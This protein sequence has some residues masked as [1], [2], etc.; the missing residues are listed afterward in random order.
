MTNQADHADELRILGCGDAAFLAEFPNLDSVL[1]H[2][3]GLTKGGPAAGSLPAGVIDVVPAARTILVTF[4]PSVIEGAAVHHWIR[5]TPPERSGAPVGSEV[6]IE[7]RY[8]GPDLSDVAH[9][10]GVSEAQVVNL[11]TGSAWTA[12][13][14][15][16]APGFVYL[17]TD[18]ARLHV[19]RRSNP[20]TTV[21]AGAVGL[22]GE[23]S[24]VYPRQS[25]GGWQLIGTTT[26]V[27]WD[28]SRREPALIQPGD[29][30][31]FVEA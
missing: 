17:V 25:P 12:A 22:A 7:V 2:Y 3:R 21:P 20:R 18:H 31:R 4:N 24:G 11:H 13:F 27:L 19:P 30:V 9:H 29:T 6:Q 1:A 10:L 5:S 14:S 15:G 8:G 16:F 28:A 26:A 23:F